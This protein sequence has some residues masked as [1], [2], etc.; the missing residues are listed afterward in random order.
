[1]FP[2]CF[3]YVFCMLWA[4]SICFGQ[5]LICYSL[6]KYGNSVNSKSNLFIKPLFSSILYAPSN[7]TSWHTLFGRYPSL[8]GNFWSTGPNPMIWGD[9]SSS[10]GVLSV[11]RYV[12]STIYVII[13]KMCGIQRRIRGKRSHVISWPHSWDIHKIFAES[14]W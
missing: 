10:L 9:S 12:I 4:V 8:Y 11:C 6:T 14:Q 1:M 3:L 2:I 13:C 5:G 7:H